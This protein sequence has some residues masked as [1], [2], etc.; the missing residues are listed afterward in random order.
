MPV[1]A[2]FNQPTGI[3]VCKQTKRLFVCDTGN[4]ALRIVNLPSGRVETLAQLP[5]ST[6][7]AA[8]E[9]NWTL[10]DFDIICRREESVQDTLW[11]QSP[12]IRHSFA[13]VSRCP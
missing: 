10:F 9:R 6:Y 2:R 12:C 4:D 1:L 7:V 3:C 11:E 13:P 5:K 8:K